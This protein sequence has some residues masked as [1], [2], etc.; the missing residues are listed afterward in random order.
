MA[1]IAGIT[2]GLGLSE[3]SSDYIHRPW[4]FIH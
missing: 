4:R 3:G 1:A 2:V